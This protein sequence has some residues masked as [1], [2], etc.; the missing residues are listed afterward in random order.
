MV[1]KISPEIS[2][3]EQTIIEQVET[4]ETVCLLHTM[5]TRA[6]GSRAY[7]ADTLELILAK[8]L[9]HKTWASKDNKPQITNYK[10][11]S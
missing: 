3:C 2:F 7:L 9:F 10:I 8:K 11:K 4:L 6:A 5:Q 1:P